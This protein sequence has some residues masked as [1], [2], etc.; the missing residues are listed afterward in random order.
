MRGLGRQRTDGSSADG[1]SE[2]VVLGRLR[3]SFGRAR[4]NGDGG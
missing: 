3:S 2:A 4:G 1:S